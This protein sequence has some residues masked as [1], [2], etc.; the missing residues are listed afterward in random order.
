MIK[1]EY[2]EIK[3]ALAKYGFLYDDLPDHLT[4]TGSFTFED[5]ANTTFD[6]IL[7]YDMDNRSSLTN[8]A[9]LISYPFEYNAVVAALPCS[10]DLSTNLNE[11]SLTSEKQS[12]ITDFDKTLIE[13]ISNAPGIE[14]I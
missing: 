12:I 5:L 11:L 7:T 6:Q 3:K 13:F 1:Q 10:V 14:L 4:F 9:M 8:E 2:P